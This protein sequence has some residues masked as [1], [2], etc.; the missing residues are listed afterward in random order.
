MMPDTTPPRTDAPLHPEPPHSKPPRPRHGWLNW[1]VG[2]VA[3]VLAAVVAATGI[4]AR[5]TSYDSQAAWTRAQATP[6]VAVHTPTTETT[7]RSLT[8]PGDIEAY[9]QAPIYARVNGYV[10][11]WY[12]DI[13]DRVHAGD[14]LATIDA[15][16]LDQQMRQMKADLLTA[17]TNQKL[18]ETTA[19]RWQALVA[20]NSVSIQST[21]EKVADAAARAAL[22][23]AAQANV[24]RIQA[25]LDFKQLV[26]PFDG[27]VTAR[28]TDIGQLIS[29]GSAASDRELFVVADLHRMRIYVRV[30]QVDSALIA[31]GMKASLRL[32]Q[33]P[34]RT[35]SAE[36]VTTANAI[37][38]QSRTVLVELQ[39]DN[40]KGELWPGTFAQV[41]FQLP[42]NPDLL[43]IPSGALVFQEHGA[44]VATVGADDRVHL[45][46]VTI[47]QDEG[48]KLEVLSGLTAQD[49]VIDSPPDTLAE[50]ET[51]RIAGPDPRPS[52]AEAAER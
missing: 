22:A 41:T 49:R 33:Y 44:Q 40:P 51:V 48:T 8:L 17:Q 11:M 25:M 39:A 6:T 52:Q 24:D 19:R 26:A 47:G 5:Q 42:G 29:A 30:P 3:L 15:P 12:K 18:A 2:L 35:F 50:G 16:E 38:P 27:V 43:L 34:D 10:K 36:V 37:D 9:Y 32:P 23:K 31:H 4:L 13:G 20:S 21:D 46:D 7:A 28:R 1:L 45:K 14:V